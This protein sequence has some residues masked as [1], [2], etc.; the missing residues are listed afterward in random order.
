MNHKNRKLFIFDLDGTLIER[1]QEPDGGTRPANT[2]D[3]VKLLP[4]VK[5]KIAELREQRHI[6]AIATNQGGV[7][8]G[9]TTEENVWSVLNEVD[10]QCGRQF[11]SRKACFYDPSARHGLLD[12]RPEYA[13]HTIFR[14]PWPGMLFQ[15]MMELD[16]DQD[17]VFYIGDQ[18]SDLE[19]ANR[20]GVKFRNAEFFFKPTPPDAGIGRRGEQAE[21]EE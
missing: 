5:K 10:K 9:F 1:V 6:V 7:A 16:F 14:K 8:W 13:S 17:D 18:P 20:A 21:Q 3:E 11:C 2:P 15:I 4:G 12:T 19:T